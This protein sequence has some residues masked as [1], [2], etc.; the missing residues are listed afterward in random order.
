VGTCAGE[1]RKLTWMGERAI[2]QDGSGLPAF[3]IGDGGNQQHDTIIFS[4]LYLNSTR[5]CE[6]NDI[7]MLH[8]IC[9]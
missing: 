1:V 7:Y 3:E 2:R 5:Q 4:C 9:R 6:L 8:N